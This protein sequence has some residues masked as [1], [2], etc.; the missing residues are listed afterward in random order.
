MRVKH[1]V[2]RG[3]ALTITVDGAPASAFKGETIATAMLAAGREGF[4]LDGRERP[5]GMFCNMGTCSECFVTV[6]VDGK[7]RRLRACLTEVRDG[8]AVET[9]LEHDC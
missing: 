5:R 6:R 8:M 4:R 1:G 7:G 9:G 3:P 2:V